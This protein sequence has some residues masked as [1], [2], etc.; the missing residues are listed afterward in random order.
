MVCLKDWYTRTEVANLL[1]VSKSTVYNYAKQNKIIKIDDPHRLMREARYQKEEVDELA[2]KRKRN[3]P[4]GLRP[5]ELANELDVPT[6]RIYTLI[7]ETELPVDQLPVGDERWIYSIPPETAQW[8]RQRVQKTAPTRG[9]RAEFYD[10]T[11][12]IALYQR[13]KAIEGEEL[14]VVRNDDQE[15]G[16]YLPSG[17]WIPYADGIDIFKYKPIYSIH[18]RN[19]SVRGYT[20]FTLP[21]EE[22]AYLFLDFVYQVWGIE[23]IRIRE[24]DTQLDLSIKSGEVTVPADIYLPVSNDTVE[25]YL[26]LGDMVIDEKKWILISGYRRT[27]FDL[28][29][30]LLVKLRD[31]AESE[32]LSMSQYVELVLQEK[33]E[34]ESRDS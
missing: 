31:I 10:A 22:E 2:K 27:T 13:F 23:N 28:P 1:G 4:T 19:M 21:K 12:D 33:L 29:D 24:Q 15:W 16:F 18:Q 11:F 3:E 32:G 6:Q 8:I 5:S 7:H 25:E 9:T 17:T 26:I 30:H 14:R 34:L 20:D